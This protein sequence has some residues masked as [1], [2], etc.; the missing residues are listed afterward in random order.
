[1]HATVRRYEGVDVSRTGELKM[2]VNETLIPRLSKVPGF[3]SYYLFEADNGVMSSFSLFDNSSPPTRRPS[4][5]PA[6]CVTRSSSPCFPTRRRSPSARSSP[7]R[8]AAQSRKHLA[9]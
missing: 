7:R 9:A 5:S 2:K 4:S 1:M 8:T 3:K 6:G